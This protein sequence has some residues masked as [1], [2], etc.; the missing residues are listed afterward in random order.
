M[1][2]NERTHYKFEFDAKPFPPNYEHV[3]RMPVDGL[4]PAW[5]RTFWG[6]LRTLFNGR[7]PAG[8]K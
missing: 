4:F 1:A 3:R 6:Y 5:N 7:A 2:E 8:F